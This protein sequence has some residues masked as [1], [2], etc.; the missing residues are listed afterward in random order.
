MGTERSRTDDE[1]STEESISKISVG[2]NVGGRIVTMVMLGVFLAGLPPTRWFLAAS[3]AL[4]VVVAPILRWTAR[5][6]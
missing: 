4:K 1:A 6:R 2:G 3:M 5:D